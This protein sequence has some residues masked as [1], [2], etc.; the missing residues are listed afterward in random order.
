MSGPNPKPR[1]E[2][3]LR[4]ESIQ[5]EY[6]LGETTVRALD[7][8]DLEICRGDYSAILGPSGSG[9]STLMHI[10]GF[11]DQPT[12]G[13]MFMGDRDVS[14]IHRGEQAQ[15]RATE[16]GFVFQS[17]NLLSRLSV[18]ENVLLPVEYARRKMEQPDKT[19]KEM[20]DRV[21]LSHRVHH[22]PSQLSGGERQRV[23]IARAMINRPRILLAD[24]P[25]GNLD[26]R[27]A[28]NI[29]DLFDRLADEGNTLVLVTHDESIAQRTRR[30]I[31]VLDGKV[32]EEEV[33]R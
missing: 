24:E 5:K 10:L 2:T 31:R 18:I 22:R 20:L 14:R 1:G 13:K 30:V 7:G 23:A 9:K 25:T 6:E 33:E 3:L 16:I 27:N 11:M 28:A 19:A 15:L 29:L 26:S 17:F 21:G 4:L 8:V 12:G 32:T